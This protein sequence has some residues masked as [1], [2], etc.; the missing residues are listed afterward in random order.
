MYSSAKARDDLIPNMLEFLIEVSY[1][2]LVLIYVF[3]L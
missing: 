1:T 2:P 3:T